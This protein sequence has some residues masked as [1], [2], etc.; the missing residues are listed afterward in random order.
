LNAGFVKAGDRYEKDSD[1]RVQ[2]AITLVVRGTAAAT[3][4]I[5]ALR[6]AARSHTKRK[7]AGL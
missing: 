7:T 3:P 5:A 2:K 6:S 1:R 4:D